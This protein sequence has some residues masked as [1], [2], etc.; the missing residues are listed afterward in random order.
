MWLPGH[1]LNPCIR[2]RISAS[3]YA[4]PQAFGH[5]V[6][7]HSVAELLAVLLIQQV[8]YATALPLLTAPTHSLTRRFPHFAPS[9]P[10]LPEASSPASAPPSKR[11]SSGLRSELSSSSSSSRSATLSAAAS[12]SRARPAAAARP[13]AK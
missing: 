12:T 11:G 7:E 1:F 4:Y 2:A 10:R 9:P 8:R 13:R 5:D 6:A 3:V